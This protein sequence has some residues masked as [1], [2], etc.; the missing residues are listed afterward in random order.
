M[1]KVILIIAIIVFALFSNAQPSSIIPA[2]VTTPAK[3]GIIKGKI[4]EQGSNFPLEYAN[5]AIYSVVDSSLAGGAITAANGQFII[6]GIENGEYY[7]DAKFIG[8]EHTF[9]PHFKIENNKRDFDLGLLKLVPASENIREVNVVAQ[10][11]PIIYDIDKKII[12]PAMFPTTANGTATDVLANTPSVVVDVEGNITMRGSSNFTV[13]IDGR[14]TPFDPA[15][16]LDQI[17]AS[18]IRN[19][20]IITNPS[21]KFD[22]DGNAGI[23]NINTKK[24]KLIGVSGIVN[25]SGDTNGSYSG[26][27]LLNFKREK[28]NFY[29]SGNLSDRKQTGEFYSLNKTF[30]TADTLTIESE[31]LS[32]RGFKGWSFKT[33]LDYYFNEMNTLSFNVGANGRNRYNNSLASFNE[34]SSSGK[35]LSSLTESL[36]EGI[37]TE[38]STSLDYR[39][40][41]KRKGQE[42]TAFLYFQNGKGDDYSLYDQFEGERL[43]IAGQKSWEVGSEQQYRLKTDYVHPFTSKMKLEAGYQARIDRSLEW[44]DVHWY[45]TPDS[46]EP[47]SQSD[48]FSEVNFS[49]DIHSLYST[50][51]NS[52]EVVGLQLGLRTEYTDRQLNYS[53]TDSIYAINRFDWFPSLHLSFQLP[54]DQQIIASY[55]RRIQRP[56]SQF[57]EPFLTYVDAYNVRVGNP[58][59]EP[60][61]I[62]SYELGYQKQIGKGF[63]SAEVYHRTTNNKI[64]RLQSVYSEN[65]MM[66]TFANIGA[67]YSTGLELMLN[68]NPAKWWMLNVMG[69]A[70]RYSIEGHVNG[71]NINIDPSFNW[72]GRVSN[73]FSITKKTKLQFDAM[74]NSP[75]ITAQ[76]SRKGFLFSNLAVRQDLLDNKLNITLSIRDIFNT[77]KFGFESAGSNF[78]S[79]RS[80][81]MKSRVVSLSLSYKINNYRK[82]VGSNGANSESQM[83]EMEDMG[84]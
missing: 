12:D 61:Y 82:K 71:N 16:A 18:T 75:T 21:A 15:D 20:E 65:V 32:K 14:P 6:S 70:Y 1:K 84:M 66:Q 8:Y 51:S 56:R 36:G 52:G 39:K 22:P 67:D 48:Y 23:I 69:N 74:Y 55:S 80:F 5:V 28:V 78:Y 73:V 19:I 29:V 68:T 30:A 59:I 11:R 37:G 46:Y 47:S 7:A 79:E 63:L 44:N 83:I 4:I 27:F 9:S 40:T 60:E 25:G 35:N 2:D 31:G 24:S 50:F 77:A 54:A 43:L 38:L 62:D 72:N 53:K 64:E 17:P 49:R 13:L 33:G 45:N 57:L 42:F 10:N 41:F 58:S 81:S 76:G 26:D 34:Y 3:K